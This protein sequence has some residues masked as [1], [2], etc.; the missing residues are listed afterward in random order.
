[1]RKTF[2]LV[3]WAV[4]GACATTSSSAH[5]TEGLGGT[6]T[7]AEVDGQPLPAASPTEDGVTLEAGSLSLASGGAYTLEVRARTR[8]S[9]AVTHTVRGTFESNGMTFRREG[10]VR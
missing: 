5:R 1:M 7:L 2:L 3:A 8:S 9:E 10:D 6:W 4:L